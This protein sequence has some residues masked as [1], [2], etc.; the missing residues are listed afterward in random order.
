MSKKSKKIK[1]DEV[2]LM[3]L[4]NERTP[5]KGNML[6]ML[7]KA[8][9]VGQLAYMDGMDPDTGD[10]VPLIVGLEPSED[11]TKS[12]IWPLAKIIGKSAEI[13]NYLIPDGVGGYF[14]ARNESI[15]KA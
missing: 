12:N 5:M 1:A 9:S 14:D 11:G 2:P 4:T 6:M 15:A 13:K 10:I 3:V 7:Y 8:A